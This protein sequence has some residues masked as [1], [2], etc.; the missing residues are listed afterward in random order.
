[1]AERVWS[2]TPPGRTKYDWPSI[3]EDLHSKPG[4]WMLIDDQASRWLANAI[5]RR[6]MRALQNDGWQ[7]LTRTKSNGERREV[8]MTA[9]RLE[10]SD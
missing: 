8:W 9:K 1:M 2:T 5:N 6:K 10:L 4:V 3:V 7:Y